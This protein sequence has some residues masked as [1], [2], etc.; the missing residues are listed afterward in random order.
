MFEISLKVT[1]PISKK[2]NYSVFLIP[3]FNI[4]TLHEIHPK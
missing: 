2:K 3:L 4:N 1:Q